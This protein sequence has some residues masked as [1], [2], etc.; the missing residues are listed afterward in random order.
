MTLNK[1]VVGMAP[2]PDGAGYWLVAS[3][4]GI[5]SFGDATFYGSAGGTT[6]NAP[7]VGMAARPTG[8]GYWLVAADGGIFSY[9]DAPFE[10]SAGGTTLNA[11]VV[12]MAVT[13]SGAGYWLVASDGGIFTYGDAAFEGSAGGMSLNEPVAGMGRTVDGAGYWLVATDGGVFSYGDAPYLGN[14]QGSSCSSGAPQVCTQGSNGCYSWTAA[15]ACASGQV[16]ANGTCQTSCSDACTAG[17]SQCSGSEIQVCG[18][19]GSAPCTVWS[20]AAACPSGQSCA[21]GVCASPTCT[22]ACEPG[23][24]KCTNGELVSCNATTTGGCHTWGTPTACQ[25]HQTCRTNGCVSTTVGKADGGSVDDG[26]GTN[27]DGSTSA[28]GGQG[29]HAKDAAADH[30]E[31][32]G[33]GKALDARAPNGGASDAGGFGDATDGV[34]TGSTGGGCTVSGHESDDRSGLLAMT[35]VGLAALRRRRQGAD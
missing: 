2:T 1:P 35:L 12:G 21:S 24:T 23:A 4:G 27:E 14:A 25:A 20:A 3:D 29:D 31:D 28:D 26:G 13:A 11:P 19:Y 16:C 10:G 30:H 33:R 9:G 34:T 15:A 7:V 32:G 8:K 5:F 22:D 6:L 18:R 17:E